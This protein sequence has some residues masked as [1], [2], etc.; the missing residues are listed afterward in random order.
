LGPYGANVWI[1]CGSGQPLILSG[2][3]S[4]SV[5]QRAPHACGAGGTPAGAEAAH[6]RRSGEY[7]SVWVAVALPWAISDA[8]G[9]VTRCDPQLVHT[10][11]LRI[12]HSQVSAPLG[13]TVGSATPLATGVCQWTQHGTPGEVLL[14][15]DV[16]VVTPE[17][18]TRVKTVTI[19]TVTI[20]GGLGDEAFYSTFTQGHT[21]L[22]TL[23]IK[24]GTAAVTIRVSGGTKP[25]EEYQAKEKAVAVALLSKL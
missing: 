10:S 3:S 13:G 9:R 2:N 22:T 11:E 7:S 15:R 19:G 16:N 6:G 1:A 14:K 12:R 8:D 21:T 20:V 18:F 23:N 4:N 5:L 25:A 17:R 24:K